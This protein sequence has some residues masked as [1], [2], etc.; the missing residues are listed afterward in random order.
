MRVP[1]RSVMSMNMNTH[2]RMNR[3]YT[4]IATFLRSDHQSDINDLQ[5]DYAVI[6]VPYDEGSPFMPG[7]RFGP[8][9][10]REHSLRFGPSGPYGPPGFPGDPGPH[11]YDGP[12]GYSGSNG[13]PGPPGPRGLVGNSIMM[14][15]RHS[16]NDQVRITARFCRSSSNARL[17]ICRSSSKNHCETR[18]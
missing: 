16:Q 8:R 4:G 9:S 10:I 13:L 2:D 5:A 18:S 15:A 12:P 17:E 7:S 3:G 11:G 1:S 14:Y 6:G